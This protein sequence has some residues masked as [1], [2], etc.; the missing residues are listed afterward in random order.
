[1]NMPNAPHHQRG[2]VLI[3]ALIML[4]LLTIIGISSMRGTTLQERMAGNLRDDSLAF[5]ASEAAMRQGEAVV[6]AQTISYWQNYV[7][8]PSWQNA[9]TMGDVATPKYKITPLPGI[10]LIQAGDSLEAGTPITSAV[11]RV[12]AEGYGVNK[13]ADNATSSSAVQLRSLYIKR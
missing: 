12:E 10:S 6:K 9:A 8:T 4:L 11:V 7:T 2:A 13:N 1:M 3:V 5:Q